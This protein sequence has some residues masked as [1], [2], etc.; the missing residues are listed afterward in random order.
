[1]HGTCIK[2]NII[3]VSVATVSYT[4]R[5]PHVVLTKVIVYSCTYTYVVLYLSAS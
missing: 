5:D 4:Q 2:K 1:M 3:A